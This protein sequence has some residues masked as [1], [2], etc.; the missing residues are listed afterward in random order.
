MELLKNK[1][2]PRRVNP[3]LELSEKMQE[4]K[5]ILDQFIK[6]K[7]WRSQTY[8]LPAL[9]FDYLFLYVNT[10][11]PGKHE[12]WNYRVTDELEQDQ[13]DSITLIKKL[14]SGREMQYKLIFV[15]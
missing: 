1:V 13:F 10:V 3:R 15:L 4:G 2:E 12:Q 7:G 14:P 8:V 6:D 9:I 5:S 11:L